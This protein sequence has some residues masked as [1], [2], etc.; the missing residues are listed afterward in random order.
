MQYTQFSNTGAQVSKLCLGTMNF[1]QQCDE[2]N[3]HEQLD[4]AISRGITM[5]DTAEVYP[6]PPDREKQ[7]STEVMIGNWIEKRKKRDDFFLA[8]KVSS[9]GMASFIGRRDGSAG[10]TKQNIAVAIDGTLAR[11]KTDY[12]DLYQVHFPERRV[13]NN[14]VRGVQALDGDDGI[15]IEETLEGLD[16]VVRSGKV[17]YIGVSNENSWGIMEYL[18][19]AEQK[20]FARIKSIQNQYSILNRTFEVGLS[21]MCMREH[22]AF[23][24][25]SV[26]NMGVLTGKYLGG[27]RPEG[28]RFSLTSRSMPRY[29]PEH[30]EGQKAVA[31]YVA[32][33]QELGLKSGQLPI[34]FAASRAFTTS[35][36][37]GATSVVQLKDDIDALEIPFTKDIEDTVADIYRRMPDPTC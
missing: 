19:V 37:L 21:E 15:S 11:L 8:S 6:I 35:V 34:A 36:I 23:L 7:G 20:N 3:A 17:R 16:A 31:Q 30:E 29:N 9:R 4:Y 18:R 5:I 24:P 14:G 33:E 25:F 26:L 12:L 22:I 28:A 1:G 2:Q 27:A 13:N 32:L 10:L